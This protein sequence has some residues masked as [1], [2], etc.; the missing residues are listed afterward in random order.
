MDLRAPLP[1]D[2]AALRALLAANGWEH[3]L[4]DA[5]WFARLLAGSRAVVAVEGAAVVGFAR[6]VTDG[7]SNG[8]L[9][10]VVVAPEHRGQGIGTQLVRAVMGAD[11]G[12]TWVLRASRPGA[13]EFFARLGFTPSAEAMERPRTN[14]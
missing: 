3:R 11:A 7:V 9:S 4:G 12:V 1:P 2:H 13:R 5:Q 14:P 10:M 8:Y 6:A